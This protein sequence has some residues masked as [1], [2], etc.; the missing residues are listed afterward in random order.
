M[1]RCFY[2]KWPKTRVLGP[3]MVVPNSNPSPLF[4]TP[5]LGTPQCK[6]I[7][8]K[9]ATIWVILG[10]VYLPY[11]KGSR[12]RPPARALTRAYAR[13]RDP[14]KG[15]PKNGV[16][17]QTP[18]DSNPSPLF[19]TPYLGTPQCKG[20][21]PKYATIWVILVTVYIP[22]GKASRARPPARA[23]T[24]AYARARDPQK[25]DPQNH[26]PNSN[27]SLLFRYTHLGVPKISEKYKDK[28]LKGN[29]KGVKKGSKRA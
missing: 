26:H 14:H 23:L 15:D 18:H 16:G 27:P 17:I 4:S 22:Y 2:L 8:P 28:A 12:A 3:R 10:R 13:A 25:R 11:A 9:Y 6:G 29:Q 24:R 1:L 21:N 20:I 7:N 5:Y 19:S